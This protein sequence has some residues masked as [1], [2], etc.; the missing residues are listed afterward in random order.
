[1]HQ[2]RVADAAKV[3]NLSEIPP[4]ERTMRSSRL[5]LELLAMLNRETYVNLAKVRNDP[6]AENWVLPITSRSGQVVGQVRL[7]KSDDGAF[8]FTADTIFELPQLWEAVKDKPVIGRLSSPD[9]LLFE[10]DLYI[11]DLLRK[12][13]FGGSYNYNT[14]L[15]QLLGISVVL[16]LVMYFVVGLISHLFTRLVLRVTREDPKY[17]AYMQFATGVRTL[18]TGIYGEFLLLILDLPIGVQG[19]ATLITR[20][21]I[22]IGMVLCACAVWEAALRIYVRGFLKVDSDSERVV[23]PLVTRL[24]N[25]VI[26]VLAAIWILTSFGVNVIGLVAALGVGGLVLALA[27]KDTV[28]NLFGSVMVL[29]EKPF[30]IGDWVK[31]GEVSGI[32]EDIR[33]RSTRIRTFED[34]LVVMPN[35]RMVT[36]Y[37]EN[38]GSRRHRRMLIQLT[39]S[40]STPQSSLLNF[41]QNAEATIRSLSGIL[42]EST[43]VTLNNVS[44]SGSVVQLSTYLRADTYEEELRL[45]QSVLASIE[46]C[47]SQFG[48]ELADP[49]ATFASHLRDSGQGRIIEAT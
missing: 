28:E 5:A 10:P 16:L 12:G 11:Q 22:L 39:I 47:A 15:L 18:L 8:R 19:T 23:A 14:F 38:M 7:D 17:G 9:E 43:F 48:V 37:L 4:L 2:N 3:L 44:V 33:L 41:T 20:V 34:S 24:G 1:M 21:L 6:D 31:V 30:Q 45:R 29:F 46:A 36:T 49:A 13:G 26:Y 35:S 27:A 40:R 25:T 42:A 32:V